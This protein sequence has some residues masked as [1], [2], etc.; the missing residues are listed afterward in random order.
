MVISKKGVQLSMTF[1]VIA[2]L[3]LLIL[4]IA[5]YLIVDVVNNFREGTLCSSEGGKCFVASDCTA[6]PIYKTLVVKG[7]CNGANEICCK[8]G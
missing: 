6:N 1:V 4:A 3:S 8:P 2:I 5:A 7:S